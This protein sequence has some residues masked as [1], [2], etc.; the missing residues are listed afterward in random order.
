MRN[1]QYDTRALRYPD[2]PEL[3]PAQQEA[4]SVMCGD[5]ENLKLV[6][7]RVGVPLSQLAVWLQ[8]P[9]FQ[10]AL[11]SN[12]RA[13]LVG[14]YG[15]VLEALMVGCQ[16]PGRNQAQFIR[17]YFAQLNTMLSADSSTTTTQNH[18]DEAQVTSNLSEIPIELRIRCLE[19][20]D[21]LRDV[22]RE[23][24]I[25]VKAVQDKRPQGCIGILTETYET[26]DDET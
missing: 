22:Q 14:V 3:T 25:E 18:E 12:M 23:K 6:A 17:I 1:F 15:A 4:L 21:Q 7:E 11:L 10:S 19:I 24:V 8:E 20:L 16:K 2:A 26:L 13:N 5:G 9:A